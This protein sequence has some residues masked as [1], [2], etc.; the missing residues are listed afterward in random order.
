MR[1]WEAGAADQRRTQENASASLVSRAAQHTASDLGLALAVLGGGVLRFVGLARES[2]WLDEATSIIIARMD[3]AS[4]VAWAAGDIHPPLYYLILHFWLLLGDS[5]FVV[6][7]LSAVLGVVTI[8]VAYALG[9][10]L[11]GPRAGLLSALLLA[12]SPLHIWYS[13]EARMY[14]LVTTL[15]LL[16]SF[17]LLLA[18]RRRQTHYWLGYVLCSVLALYTHYF[19]LFGLLFQNLFALYWL[20]NKRSS[21]WS[22]WLLAQLAVVLLFL[23]WLPILYHQVTTG[24]GGWVERSIGRPTLYALVDTWLYFSIGLD[25]QL[26]PGWLRRVAYLLYGICTLAAVLSMFRLGRHETGAHSESNLEGEVFCLALAGFPILSVWLVSQIKPM[27]SVRYLLLFLPYYCILV[28]KGIDSLRWKSVS[29]ALVLF[30]ACTLL[31]GNWNTWCTEQNPDWRGVTSHVLDRA[32]PGDVVLF[33][34]RW[35]EKPFDYYSRGRLDINMD[36]P[37]PVTV[38]AAQQVLDSIRQRYRRVWL[39][40]QRGHYSDPDGVVR[41]ILD[42]QYRV[43]EQNEFR[44]VDHL[45]LYDLE[46]GS[47]L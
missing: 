16:A 39:V 29:G 25:S 22:K 6:R 38:D 24:G 45:I 19:A 10:E 1:L 7:S 36:L 41:Q 37:I 32:Q 13:Q 5:E 14:A 20:V 47:Q 4:L 33:S 27:Y 30:L 3:L 43:V 8:A 12:L 18:L 34:P 42:S 28:A 46:S 9:E 15:N 2:I 44:G 11:F 40:W 26:Y 23:P 35:N 31:L 17:C 21:L